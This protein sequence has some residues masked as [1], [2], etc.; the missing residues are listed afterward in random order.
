MS[1]EIRPIAI[2]HVDG[3]HRALD[4]VARE[5]QWLSFLEA[6]PLASTLAFV[7]GNIEAGH[8]QFVALQDAQVV[9]WC[10]VSPK[11]RPLFAHAGVLG[12][13]VVENWRGRG[14]GS[15]LIQA[16]LAHAWS[17]G[18]T[19]IELMVHARNARARA[20][21]AKVGFQ[22]EGILR[23]AIRVDGEYDDVVVMAQLRKS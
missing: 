8:A 23:D 17:R 21:Y 14:I 16:T 3:F 4:A 2:E 5:R 11:T 9:G 1:V 7:R 19:R 13:G 12:M 6:P 10:D 20:L 18:L 15:A 22:Q